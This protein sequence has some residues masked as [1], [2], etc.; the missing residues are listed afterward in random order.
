MWCLTPVVV[1]VAVGV[2][3]WQEVLAVTEI[4]L[5]ALAEVGSL[6]LLATMPGDN[7]GYSVLLVAEVLIGAFGWRQV[8]VQEIVPT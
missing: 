6:L 5:L 1:Q 7:L 2:L 4:A 8:P 3:T